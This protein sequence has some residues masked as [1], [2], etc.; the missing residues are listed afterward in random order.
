MMSDRARCSLLDRR[1]GVA[2]VTAV[3]MACTALAVA[4]RCSNVCWGH[5]CHMAVQGLVPLG[6]NMAGERAHSSI[7]NA[8]V[9]I[10]GGQCDAI[11]MH[12]P[13]E[14]LEQ[15]PVVTSCM[16]LQIRA[17]RLAQTL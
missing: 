9:H 4:H 15:H 7:C 8:V 13:L 3:M 16:H 2:S 5:T 11:R 10:A 14:A 1:S 12:R 6:H 17:N